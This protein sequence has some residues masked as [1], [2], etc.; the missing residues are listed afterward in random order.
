[1]EIFTDILHVQSPIVGYA[2]AC[3]HYFT[4]EPM[5]V[6]GVSERTKIIGKINANKIT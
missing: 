2:I 4:G 1:M 6:T 3:A 5:K